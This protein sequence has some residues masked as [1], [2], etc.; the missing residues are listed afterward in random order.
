M[1]PH[2]RKKSGQAVPFNHE[3]IE[4]TIEADKE[5]QFEMCPKWGSRNFIKTLC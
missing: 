5:R 4:T 1:C 2:D 3:H